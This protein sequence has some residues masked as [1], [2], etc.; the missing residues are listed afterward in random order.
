MHSMHRI[1]LRLYMLSGEWEIV[2]VCV[3]V[4]IY[5]YKCTSYVFIDIFTHDMQHTNMCFCIVEGEK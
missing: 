5:H 2:C 1:Q 4:Y 3:R